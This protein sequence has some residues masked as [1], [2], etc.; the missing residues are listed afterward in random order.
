[1]K[2]LTLTELMEVRGGNEDF[3]FPWDEKKVMCD[4]LQKQANDYDKYG[5]TKDEWEKW[6][7]NFYEYC[8]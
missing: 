1:M 8:I 2:Q 4:I 6:I 3:P 5:A 7:D